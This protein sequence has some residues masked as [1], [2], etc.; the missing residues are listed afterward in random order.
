MIF[1]PKSHSRKSS[2][3]NVWRKK[4]F[5]CYLQTPQLQCSN[6]YK[7][8][9]YHQTTHFSVALGLRVCLLI[10][11]SFIHINRP[12]SLD[13]VGGMALTKR[14]WGVKPQ[15]ANSSQVLRAILPINP[16]HLCHSRYVSKLCKQ[17][18]NLH[19]EGLSKDITHLSYVFCTQF[20]IA[21][22]PC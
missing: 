5:L 3:E 12:I 4:T 15:T 2:E 18:G 22:V 14:Q 21:S 6:A 19:F 13:A 17:G 10:T 9:Y 8:R 7:R 16:K 11:L 1:F 20:C